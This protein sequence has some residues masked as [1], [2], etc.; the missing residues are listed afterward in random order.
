MN[1]SFT[2]S[3]EVCLV[4]IVILVVLYLMSKLW[5]SQLEPNIRVKGTIFKI[6]FSGKSDLQFHVPC[7]DAF[8]DISKLTSSLLNLLAQ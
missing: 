8:D 6:F 2:P 3:P 1:D 4:T 7:S 5:Q